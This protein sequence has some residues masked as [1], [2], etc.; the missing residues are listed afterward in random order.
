MGLSRLIVV[1]LN[2]WERLDR[3]QHLRNNQDLEIILWDHHNSE[4]NIFADFQ[5]QDEIG[6]V[7]SLLV[8]QIKKERK[9]LKDLEFYK[10]NLETLI[11]LVLKIILLLSKRA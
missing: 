5:Y 8:K 11:F 2:R 3:M 1:D 10:R 7:T 6:A 9:V 4:G